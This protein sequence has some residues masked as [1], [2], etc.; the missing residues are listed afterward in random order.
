MAGYLLKDMYSIEFYDLLSEHLEQCVPKFESKKFK[1]LIF[2]EAF[3]HYELK[4]RMAHTADVLY[5][6][7][8]TEFDKA[9]LIIIK[10]IEHLKEKGIKE[11][12]IEFMFLPEYIAKYGIDDFRSA[13]K[14]IEIVTQFTS[15][16]FAIR[17]FI[18]KYDDKMINQMLLWSKNEHK[19]VRRLAS[20]GS[21]PRLPWAMALPKFKKNPEP[22]L[23]ILENLKNDS[24]EIVRRSV[25]N[26]LNDI[27]KD[28]PQIFIEIANRWKGVSKETD[29]I[30]K[31]AARSLLK[32]SNKLI[33]DMY[34]LDSTKIEL[35]DFNL[36]TP[37]VKMAEDLKFT[38]K[39]IN[40]GQT[41]I[42]V[43]I[44]Y[45]IY[46]K[47]SNGNLNKKVFK[48]SERQVSPNETIELN[49]S[50]SFREIT[51][52]KYYAGEHKVT[53][54]LNGEEKIAKNFI[55]IN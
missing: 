48:I 46:F 42:N 16:E 13:I 45:A 17:P 24:C 40:K 37:T 51:T 2:T 14:S 3:K 29:A 1:K 4:E 19:K 8:P 47:K 31:H 15:C 35:S 20:E 11:K 6:F 54:I 25:A 33:L 22:I 21:R 39:F 41:P 27:T 18:I 10:L 44:E 9:S 50:H 38:F 23:P 52:R 53:V 34:G 32:N 49:K 36:I 30:I 26:N 55:Y 5:Q 7:M 43:R 12:S 28:N